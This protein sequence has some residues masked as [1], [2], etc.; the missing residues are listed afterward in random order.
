MQMREAME[1]EDEHVDAGATSPS[2]S[3]AGAMMDAC[4][5]SPS[6]STAG[7]MMDTDETSP[8]KS[9]AGEMMVCTDQ[10]F[11]GHVPCGLSQ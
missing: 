7:E 5:T 8:S 10:E 2:K 6:K 9:T 3:M 1:E 11:C 4:E